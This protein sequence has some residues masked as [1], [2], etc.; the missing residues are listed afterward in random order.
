M[1]ISFHTQSNDSITEMVKRHKNA[2]FVAAHPGEYP[3]IAFHTQLAKECENYHIDISGTGVFRL[4]AI[5][6]LVKEFGIERVLYGSDYPTC[7]PANFIGSV[8]YDTILTNSQKEYILSKNA[9]RLL[10]IK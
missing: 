10:N 9:K 8:C 6:T 2:T 5:Q 4:G 7:N 3:D 1:V